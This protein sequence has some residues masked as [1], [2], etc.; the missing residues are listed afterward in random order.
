MWKSIKYRLKRWFE[1]NEL[2]PPKIRFVNEPIVNVDIS[3]EEKKND[4]IKRR[5][6][7]LDVLCYPHA[8][9]AG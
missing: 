9:K 8:K 3:N 7:N 5:K 6:N 2:G 4:K 1:F